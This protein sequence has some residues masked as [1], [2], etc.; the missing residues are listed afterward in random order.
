MT[1]RSVDFNLL[2]EK[3]T[4]STNI[5]TTAVRY[6]QETLREALSVFVNHK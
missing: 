3:V 1:G 4:T 6:E 5:F 2:Q